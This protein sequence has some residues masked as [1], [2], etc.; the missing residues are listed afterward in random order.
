[1]K[2]SEN[3]AVSGCVSSLVAQ[4]INFY[5]FPAEAEA[6]RRKL[7]VEAIGKKTV[8]ANAKLCSFHFITG[9]PSNS[10][11][12]PDYVPTLHMRSYKNVDGKDAN[13]LNHLLK[14]SNPKI[15]PDYKHQDGRD[16]SLHGFKRNL[17]PE[18]VLNVVKL[19]DGHRCFL[20]KW[21]DDLCPDF[22][23]TDDANEKCP[24][25]VIKFYEHIISWAE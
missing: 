7:W 11:E 2:T 14:S 18:K 10:P 17:K 22:V 25:L 19:K 13:E 9:S 5:P 4:K 3:C 1:M 23:T 24:D 15:Y 21:K 16:S 20:M 6:K 12:H 8:P